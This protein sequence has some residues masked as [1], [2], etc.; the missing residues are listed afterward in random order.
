MGVV[1][2]VEVLYEFL[3][4]RFSP[5]SSWSLSLLVH[6]GRGLKSSKKRSEGS[7]TFGVRG[8]WF[9]VAE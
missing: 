1:R 6:G 3:S 2:E 4:L 5:P 8:E 9:L 7:M